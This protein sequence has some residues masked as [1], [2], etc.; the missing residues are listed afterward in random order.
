MAKV[1]QTGRD[2]TIRLGVYPLIAG[3]DHLTG[4]LN[5]STV[6]SSGHHGLRRT[7]IGLEDMEGVLNPFCTGKLAKVTKGKK[8]C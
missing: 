4:P 3:G 1:S 6:F 7:Q 5:W 8:N 2:M